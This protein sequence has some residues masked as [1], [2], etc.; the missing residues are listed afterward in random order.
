MASVRIEFTVEP[1]VEGR[2]GPHVLAAIDAVTAMGLPVDVGP[3]SSVA[4]A[5]ADRAVTA[6]AALLQAA[7]AHGA[8]RVALQVE[9]APEADG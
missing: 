9:Q 4:D 7:L 2:P 6:V 5:T 3:F 1:F 8:T